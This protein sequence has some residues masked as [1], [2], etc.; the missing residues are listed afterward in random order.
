MTRATARLRDVDEL[1][2]AVEALETA[3]VALGDDPA[4]KSFLGV[5]A[6]EAI[7]AVREFARFT[8]AE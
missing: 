4:V 3:I 5:P 8:H 2:V 7:E 6:T 1:R